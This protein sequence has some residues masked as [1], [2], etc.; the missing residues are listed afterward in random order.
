[1]ARMIGVF[2]WISFLAETVLAQTPARVDFARDVQPL[3]RQNC[4]GCHGPVRQEKNLRLDRRR[5]AMSI[6]NRRVIFPGDSA[7]SPLYL[8][9]SGTLGPQMP[10]TGALTP[11][12]ISVIKAWIDQGAEWPD[13]LSGEAPASRPPTAPVDALGPR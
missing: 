6:G 5:D 11:E 2:F 9:I 4:F 10:P 13:A 8:H 7:A 1:M 12:E 3:L